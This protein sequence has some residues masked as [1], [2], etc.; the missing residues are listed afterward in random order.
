M[1]PRFQAWVTGRMVVTETNQIISTMYLFAYSIFIYIFFSFFKNNFQGCQLILTTFVIFCPAGIQG[2]F[3]STISLILLKVLLGEWQWFE[4]PNIQTFCFFKK[5]FLTVSHILT[6]IFRLSIAISRDQAWRVL[7]SQLLSID[8]NWEHV[9]VSAGVIV[10]LITMESLKDSIWQSYFL[11]SPL[12]PDFLHSCFHLVCD[13]PRQREVCPRNCISSSVPVS[14]S[15][16]CARGTKNH[17]L[18]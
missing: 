15:M 3:V 2:L 4:M 11:T 16:Q 12:S 13:P 14:S 5:I 17:S 1:R 9:F 7:C 6:K 18:K 10:W 8:S